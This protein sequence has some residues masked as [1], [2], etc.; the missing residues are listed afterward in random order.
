MG[1]RGDACKQAAPVSRPCRGSDVISFTTSIPG[2]A[3][4]GRKIWRLVHNLSVVVVAKGL[5]DGLSLCNCLMA[6]ARAI[7]SHFI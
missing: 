4:R 5:T 2:G 3:L 6:A 7:R 1:N